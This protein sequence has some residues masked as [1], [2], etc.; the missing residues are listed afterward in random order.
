MTPNRVMRDDE[1]DLTN[2][3]DCFPEMLAVLSPEGDFYRVNAALQD[4]IGP[5]SGSLIGW[6]LFAFV[7]PDDVRVATQKLER[8]VQ[9]GD[10]VSFRSRCCGSDGR[11]R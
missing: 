3:L 1:Q 2:V 11:D 7:H 10:K 8:T 6:S 4:A 9:A 5:R